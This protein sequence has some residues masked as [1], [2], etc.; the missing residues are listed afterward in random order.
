LPPIVLSFPKNNNA[1]T[2]PQKVKVV[3]RIREREIALNIHTLQRVVS[4]NTILSRKLNR[5]ANEQIDFTTFVFLFS[6][7]FTDKILK[8]YAAIY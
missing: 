5:S 8:S 4:H 6:C 7:S 1:N 2:P 3:N